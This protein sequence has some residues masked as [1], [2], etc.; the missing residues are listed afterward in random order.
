MNE[1]EKL[2]ALLE[3]TIKDIMADLDN[4]KISSHS[5]LVLSNEMSFLFKKIKELKQK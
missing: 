3:N 2:I 5:A 1:D 4:R